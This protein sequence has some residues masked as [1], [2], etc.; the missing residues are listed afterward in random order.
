[1]PSFDN[2]PISLL[3]AF[4]NKVLVISSNVGGISGLIKHTENGLLL[5]ELKSIHL[6]KKIQF[7]LQNQT[8]SLAMI[9]CAYDALPR[10]S[11]EENLPKIEKIYQNV[12]R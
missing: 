3:E 11:V 4:E 5:Q 10:Y 9:Q 6:A 12:L 1:V 8:A 7:A 2:M